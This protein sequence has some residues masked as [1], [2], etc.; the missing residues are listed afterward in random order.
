MDAIVVPLEGSPLAQ[1]AL[2]YAAALARATGGRLLL[3]RAV[4]SFAS[5]GQDADFVRA[6]AL[7]DAHAALEAAGRELRAD[8]LTA[9]TRVLWGEAAS[10]ILEVP[11]EA[12]AALIV[13][14]IHR[15]GGLGWWLFGSV[16]DRVLRGAEQPVLL[17]P[18]RCEAHWARDQRLRI[19]VP[20]DGSAFAEEALRPAEGL[21][22]ALG[23]E[24]HLLRVVVPPPSSFAPPGSNPH[25]PTL[26]FAPETELTAARDYL[27]T[28]AARF[29]RAGLPVHSSAEVG[30]AAAMIADGAR[31]LG[32]GLIA[33]A[34]HGR[35]GLGRLVLGSVATG[36]VQ[37]A[38]VPLMLLRPTALARPVAGATPTQA[39][40]P[41]SGPPPSTL[42]VPL[43]P[44]ELDHVRY[45]LELALHAAGP[46]A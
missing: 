29:A 31:T 17:V 44:A 33:M 4:L 30:E 9:D 25:D 45:G 43:S 36:V 20:L 18:P 22:R 23:A 6:E 32:C 10:T 19:L 14:S 3:V 28:V 12:D 38:R 7:A 1:T 37:H 39:A 11:R 16:A 2:P 46:D 26:F 41:P 5:R 24:L 34:T 40:A 8:G 35:S 21:T 42:A 15:R 27:E 13:M